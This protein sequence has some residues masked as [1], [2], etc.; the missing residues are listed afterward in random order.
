M[1]NEYQQGIYRLNSYYHSSVKNPDLK[2]KNY[3]II[4]FIYCSNDNMSF[5]YRMQ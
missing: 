4:I 5:I 2:S 3:E 1:C